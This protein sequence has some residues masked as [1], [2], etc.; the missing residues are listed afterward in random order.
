MDIP[1]AFSRVETARELERGNVNRQLVV[2]GLVRDL[3]GALVREDAAALTER[4]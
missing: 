3:R 4:V 2:S 1:A